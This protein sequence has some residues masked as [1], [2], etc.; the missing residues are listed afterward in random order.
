MVKFLLAFNKNSASPVQTVIACALA[1]DCEPVIRRGQ[2]ANLKKAFSRT[3]LSLFKMW[4]PRSGIT[5]SRHWRKSLKGQSDKLEDMAKLTTLHKNKLAHIHPQGSFLSSTS[6][7]SSASQMSLSLRI[8]EKRDTRSVQVLVQQC[9]L[10]LCL[11]KDKEKVKDRDKDK[12]NSSWRAYHQSQTK[13]PWLKTVPLG[14]RK[15]TG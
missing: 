12:H 6:N 10:N 5:K 3:L 7:S 4:F 14:Q 15:D 9:L 8:P 11:D 1:C 2:F 13:T